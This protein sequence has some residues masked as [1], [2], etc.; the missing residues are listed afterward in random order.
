[1]VRGTEETDLL[2]E[3][4]RATKDQ[5]ASEQFLLGNRELELVFQQPG[6]SSSRRPGRG[7]SLSVDQ[8]IITHRGFV[9]LGS[10]CQVTLATHEN[11]ERIGLE[12]TV[13]FCRHRSGQTHQ[14]VVRFVNK[15]DPRNFV[16]TAGGIDARARDLM[17]LTGGVLLIEPDEAIRR[18][19]THILHQTRIELSMGT[20]VKESLEEVDIKALDAIW[21]DLSDA[22]GAA[23]SVVEISESGFTGPIIGLV[24]YDEPDPPMRPESDPVQHWLRKPFTQQEVLDLLWQLP[25]ESKKGSNGETIH[26]ELENDPSMAELIRWYK[27]NV[28]KA[29]ELIE[30]A[31]ASDKR[32]DVGRYCRMLGDTAATYG[33]PQVGELAG[34][35]HHCLDVAGA[36]DAAS[37]SLEELKAMIRRMG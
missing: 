16:A 23:S 22:P 7:I 13:D 27:E 36:A 20:C 25:N 9:H 8:I 10:Q 6:G 3:I 11:T 29:L 19:F 37:A 33:Y 2:Q 26:S 31:E 34:E 35:V 15:I 12:G 28:H 5:G 32:E 4:D 1:M 14:S 30:A 17:D 18:F 24:A 21:I